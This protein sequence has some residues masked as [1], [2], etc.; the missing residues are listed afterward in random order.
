[1]CAFYQIPCLMILGCVKLY[2]FFCYLFPFFLYKKKEFFD[3]KNNPALSNFSPEHYIIWCLWLPY[4]GFNLLKNKRT[5]STIAKLRSFGI[6]F[7]TNAKTISYLSLRESSVW[8]EKKVDL[9]VY[10]F[11]DFFH[12]KSL[13]L[14]SGLLNIT[15]EN[16]F[17]YIFSI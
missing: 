8:K 5:T 2:F 16:V 9:I 13:H 10:E 6:T 4:N 11:I 7:H 12:T 15:K 14:I 1:M 3:K 17:Q